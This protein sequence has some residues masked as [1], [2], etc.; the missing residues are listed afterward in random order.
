[1]V[2]AAFM[3]A[4][5]AVVGIGTGSVTA[6]ELKPGADLTADE[7][8]LLSDALGDALSFPMLSS[9]ARLGVLGFEAVVATGGPMAS[10]SSSWW[11]NGVEGSPTIG[12]MPANRVIVRKGLPA[13]FDVGIQAGRVLDHSFWG[14]EGSWSVLEG[15]VL[16]PAVAIRGSHARL[17][18]APINVEV[19]EVG[20]AVSKGFVLVTPFAAAAYRWTRAD[21]RWGPA[22]ELAAEHH[23]E[24]LVVR[25]GVRVA[26]GPAFVSAEG[27]HGSRRGVLVGAGVRL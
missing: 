27:F 13:R 5:M 8:A 4:L 26:L 15:G 19:S 17:A 18:G 23:G 20:V 9:A 1:M 11:R 21:G 2:R 16:V 25:A 24:R 7:F 14:V 6:A 3:F 10:G 22:G 12:F